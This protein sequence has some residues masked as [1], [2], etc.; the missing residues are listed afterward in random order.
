MI[1]EEQKKQIGELRNSGLTIKQTAL[2]LEMSES[3]VKKYS[4]DNPD[5]DK[6]IDGELS[7][8]LANIM[9]LEGYDFEDE[10]KLLSYVLKNQANELDITLY[11]YMNDINSNTNKFLRITDNPIRLYYI[12]MLFASNLN[13]ITDHI[14]AEDLTNAVNNFIDR[15][16]SMEKAEVYITYCDEHLEEIWKAWEVKIQKATND[17]HEIVKGRKKHKGEQN[18][19][20][21]ETNTKQQAQINQLKEAI[22]IF[23]QKLQEALEKNNTLSIFS[24]KS[25]ENDKIQKTQITELSTEI[26]ELKKLLETPDKEKAILKKAFERIGADF[27]EEVNIIIEEMANELQ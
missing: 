18:K 7:N 15:E 4:S 5:K 3:S 2:A 13:L 25:I 14:N 12:F 1:T 22:G 24:K 8:E 9:L 26:Q 23:K 10:V 27:P 17:Y 19:R 6:E 11:D 16:V 20:L 21:H